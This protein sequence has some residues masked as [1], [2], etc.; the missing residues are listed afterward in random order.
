MSPA[1][2]GVMD[3]YEICVFQ[4]VLSKGRPNLQRNLPIPAM[5]AMAGSNII[6]A[7]IE[8]SIPDGS[9]I[10]SELI[11][12]T[13]QTRHEY[14]TKH[15][16][17]FPIRPSQTPLLHADRQSGNKAAANFSALNNVHKLNT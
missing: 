10:N 15:K 14:K 1:V 3:V 8:G 6:I 17:A 13:Y 5:N 11:S 2:F 16:G 7:S 12:V 9:R 4:Y